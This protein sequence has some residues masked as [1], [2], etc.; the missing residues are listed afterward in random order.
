MLVEN[1]ITFHSFRDEEI[2]ELLA[3][4]SNNTTR[5]TTS[6]IF[7]ELNNPLSA[8]LA[9]KQEIKDELNIDGGMHV[10]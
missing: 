2:G 5:R 6:A 8:K 4:N 9:D 10:F 3:K 1:G 7:T